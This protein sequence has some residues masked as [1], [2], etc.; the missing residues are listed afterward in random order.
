MPTPPNGGCEAAIIPDKGATK[1]RTFD[2]QRSLMRLKSNQVDIWQC[3]PRTLGSHEIGACLSTISRNELARYQRFQKS[4]AKLHFLVGRALV[5]AALSHYSETSPREWR[6]TANEHG[7][8]SVDGPVNQPLHFSLS[9]TPGLVVVAIS[10]TPEIGVDV[11]TIDRQVDLSGVAEMVFTEAELK[12]IF[13]GGPDDYWEQ[14]FGLWTVKEAYLK[15]RGTGFALSPLTFAFAGIKEPIA[16]LSPP[17]CDP[18]PER[19]QFRLSRPSRAIRMALA[20]GNRSVACIGQFDWKPVR[21]K[22]LV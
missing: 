22:A 8:P 10:R 19:W 13:R 2:G 12:W 21:S 11:E 14:F 1:D 7:R 6:F 9:H 5:R 20:I 15:A 17:T 16:F 4:E 18:H 3:R